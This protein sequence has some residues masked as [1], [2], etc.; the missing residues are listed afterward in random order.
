MDGS[1][2]GRTDVFERNNTVG[3]DLL[4]NFAGLSLSAEYHLLSRNAFG[5]RTSAT[6]WH[7]R[8]GYGVNVGAH[9]LEH[10]ALFFRG[11]G[12]ANAPALTGTD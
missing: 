2:Q 11:D 1:T 6:V 4:V 7:L 12:Q 10:F 8:A 5:V 3:G 9:V